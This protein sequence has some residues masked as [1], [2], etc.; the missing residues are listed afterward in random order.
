MSQITDIVLETFRLNGELLTAGDRLVADLSL[1]SARWQVM[2][3]IGLAQTPLP[4]A[5]IARNM[6]LSRQAVQRLVNELAVQGVVDFAPNPY[7]LRAKLVILTPRGKDI[8]AAAMQRQGP[9]ADA[10]ADSLTV[11]E[12]DTALRVLR[13]LRERLQSQNDRYAKEASHVEE[14]T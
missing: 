8:F 1:T 11:F 3:A 4:V 2:G 5:H 10:L 7:H 12:I 14:F 13:A 6:G 9:W